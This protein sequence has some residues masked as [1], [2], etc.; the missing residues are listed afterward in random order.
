[1][2]PSEAATTKDNKDESATV[3][4][5]VFAKIYGFPHWPARVH[6][7]QDGRVSVVFSDGLKGENAQVLDFTLENLRRILKTG[8]FKKTGGHS[9]NVFMKEASNLGL[10]AE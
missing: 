3:G 8:K 6:N 7:I 9:K 2:E 10:S 5:K 4:K 1:M